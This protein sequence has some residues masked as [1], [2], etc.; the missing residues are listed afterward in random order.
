MTVHHL[1]G[2][3]SVSGCVSR[4]TGDRQQAAGSTCWLDIKATHHGSSFL[5]IA[6]NCA[7]SAC[8]GVK[9]NDGTTCSRSQLLHSPPSDCCRAACRLCALLPARNDQQRCKLINGV[10]RNTMLQ[11]MKENW[12]QQG[13]SCC[14][15]ASSTSSES[16]A[17]CKPR[18]SLACA[19]HLDFHTVM[20]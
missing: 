14:E 13:S 20:P 17:G 3:T 16:S 2:M 11:C 6:S 18:L 10:Q 15:L 4:R 8:C 7:C 19:W 1:Q 9:S 12:Q 5:L